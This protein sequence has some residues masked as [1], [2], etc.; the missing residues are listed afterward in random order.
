MRGNFYNKDM[1][2]MA[3]SVYHGMIAIGSS[4]SDVY[5]WDY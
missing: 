5:V 3:F 2:A 4:C 1:T